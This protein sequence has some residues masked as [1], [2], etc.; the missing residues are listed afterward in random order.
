MQARVGRSGWSDE[1]TRALMDA[2]QGNA[3]GGH[4]RCAASVLT[5]II[6]KPTADRLIGDVGAKGLT[7]QTR[8]AGICQTEG[9]GIVK[10]SG[11]VHPFAVYDEHL[12]LYSETLHRRLAIGDKIEIIPNHICPVCNLYDTAWLVSHGEVVGPLDIAARGKLQ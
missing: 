3:L 6:S 1:E 5:T 10:G 4:S 8:P 12:I 2:A 9:Y 11:G 7:A